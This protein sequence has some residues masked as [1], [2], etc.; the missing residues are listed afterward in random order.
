MSSLS[1]QLCFLLVVDG[2]K[3]TFWISYSGSNTFFHNLGLTNSHYYLQ[4]DI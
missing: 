1:E 3:G 4:F 2:L